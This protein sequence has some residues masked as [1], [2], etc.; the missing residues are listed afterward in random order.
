MTTEEIAHILKDGF[1]EAVTSVEL[2]SCRPYVVIGA[3]RWR[4]VAGFLRDDER[5]GFNMLQ[6]ITAIDLLE[7]NQLAAIYDMFSFPVVS[8]GPCAM[9]RHHFAVRVT[10][11]RDA[12]H[13]PTVSDVWPTA[14]WHEREAY[15]MM[16]I[17][18][19]GHPEL[20]RILCP[21]DWEGFP[22]RKDY[23]FPIE[24]H[25]IPATTEHQL[26]NPRH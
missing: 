20:T 9:L 19:D 26:T 14:D 2:S 5:M 24:Y 18:F 21:D 3:E 4:E 10:V 23:E 6:C 15:D 16:G 12:P 17:V 8:V 25:G 1:G 11:D 22:L 13:I 7:D